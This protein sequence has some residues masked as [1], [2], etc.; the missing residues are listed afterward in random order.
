MVGFVEKISSM[1]SSNG[2]MGAFKTPSENETP[3]TLN[4]RVIRESSGLFNSFAMFDN[5]SQNEIG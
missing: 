4:I 1:D 5:A 2:A 3:N